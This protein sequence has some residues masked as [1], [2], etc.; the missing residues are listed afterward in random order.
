MVSLE[1]DCCEIFRSD[2]ERVARVRESLAG[3]AG[4]VEIFKALSDETRLKIVC[5]LLQEELCTC[6]LA[7]VLGFS[8]PAISHHLRLLRSARLVKVRRVGKSVFY[9]LDD[10]HVSH[11]VEEATRHSHEQEAA[12]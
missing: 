3:A 2:P 1:E 4:T 10:A 6:D 9:S 12:R 7:V 8:P 11:L 5:A